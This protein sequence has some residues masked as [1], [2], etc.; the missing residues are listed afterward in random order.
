MSEAYIALEADFE[1]LIRDSIRR[2]TVQLSIRVDRPQRA[3]DFKLNLVAIN[4]FREQFQLLRHVGSGPLDPLDLIGLPGVVAERRAEATDPHEDWP[5]LSALV[6][7]ALA[8][9]QSSRA[10][11]GKAMGIE[12]LNLAEA[13][14]SRL[15]KIAERAPH[16]VSAYADRLT[17]RVRTLIESKGVTIEPRDLI[18]EVAIFAERSDIAEEITRL[19][20]HLDQFREVLNEPESA[21]R[22]LEFVVQEMGRETNTIGSKASDI[23]ISRDVVEIKGTL[24][25]IREL[26]QNVE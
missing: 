25:K 23:A 9:L 22:K 13:I 3:E 7:D 2:G 21:G 10:E 6:S 14:D 1:R 18:R 20:S 11:E 17:E 16:V 24:E 5:V 4:A 12:L 8:K 19:R 26:I 15:A